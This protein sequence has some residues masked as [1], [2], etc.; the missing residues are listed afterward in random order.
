MWQM[1]T[2]ATASSGALF[3]FERICTAISSELANRMIERNYQT[4]EGDWQN[5]P[6]RAPLLWLPQRTRL[7][8]FP[9][10]RFGQGFIDFLDLLTAYRFTKAT[11]PILPSSLLSVSSPQLS[12]LLGSSSSWKHSSASGVTLHRFITPKLAICRWCPCTID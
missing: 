10:L 1:S 12:Q 7:L 11:L 8:F 4:G 5:S 9:L 6:D 2:V 3:V